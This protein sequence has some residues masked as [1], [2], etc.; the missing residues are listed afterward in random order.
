[1]WVAGEQVLVSLA[2]AGAVPVL[3]AFL[4]LTVCV[5][6]F[7]SL[8][9]VRVERSK[10]CSIIRSRWCVSFVTCGLVNVVL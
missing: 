9:N 5:E 10:L 1:M 7:Q 8:N 4:Y 3:R 6:R 2:R